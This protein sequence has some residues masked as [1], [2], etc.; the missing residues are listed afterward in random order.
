[1]IPTALPIPT[2]AAAGMLTIRMKRF[3]KKFISFLTSPYL[4]TYINLHKKLTGL[5]TFSSTLP[6]SA[7]LV[8]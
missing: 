5:V 6:V 7:T 2:M 4:T 8:R 1:M 3:I